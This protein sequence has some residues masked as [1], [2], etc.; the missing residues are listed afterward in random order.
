[1]PKIN[2]RLQSEDELGCEVLL[3]GR[4]NVNH[5][6]QVATRVGTEEA[7]PRHVP[8][9]FTFVQKPH[10]FFVLEC[11][12]GVSVLVYMSPKRAREFAAQLDAAADHVR[13]LP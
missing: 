4:R 12:V 11:G 6:S 3:D 9:S 13:P 10:V 8:K 2:D 7:H 5:G 1:M